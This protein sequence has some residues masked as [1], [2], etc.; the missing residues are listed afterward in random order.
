MQ[1]DD[2][3]LVEAARNGDRFALDQLL[4]RHYDRIH[5]VTTRIAGGSRDADD[6][7]QEALIKI[8]KNLPT[9]DGRSSFGTWAYRIATNAALD[10]LRRRKRRPMLHS[11]DSTGDETPPEQR[12]PDPL[13][14]REVDAVADRLALDEAF[15]GIDD[16]FR[17]AVVLRDVGDLDYAEIADVLDVPVGTVKS[18]IARGRKQLAARL[19]VDE[20]PDIDPDSTTPLPADPLDTNDI[21]GRGRN[22]DVT[23]ETS[24]E[25]GNRNGHSERPNDST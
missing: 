18:R 21:A 12:R 23:H 6:A 20:L 4:R 24:R 14:N 17:T 15:D 3:E 11:I 1:T 10:E 9:F 7:C 19:R 5:A 8:V 25:R 16:D 13:A 2:L 22:H